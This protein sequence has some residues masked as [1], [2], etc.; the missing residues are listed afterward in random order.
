[1]APVGAK[2]AE[3][4]PSP[5]S[6]FQTHAAR[7]LA[8]GGR[9]SLGCNCH[10]RLASTDPAAPTDPAS[11]D[12]VTVASAPPSTEYFS[13]GQSWCRFS[14]IQRG[15]I[16]AQ[17]AE[18]RRVEYIDCTQGS[19]TA[20]HKACLVQAK[21]FPYVVKCEPGQECT[22]VKYGAMPAEQLEQLALT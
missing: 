21:G 2:C 8:A 11:T 1:M 7:M 10:T 20:G 18:S 16:E 9:R 15:V 19:A 3:S 14:N 13:A 6:A 12:P 4:R 22:I 5:S 17:P